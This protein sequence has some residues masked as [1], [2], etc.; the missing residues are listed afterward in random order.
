MNPTI[1]QDEMGVLELA[2]RYG[3]GLDLSGQRIPARVKAAARECARKGFL[4][5]KPKSYSLTDS[6]RS[7]LAHDSEIV[8]PAG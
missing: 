4:A 6:G 5:G 8:H 2:Q 1:T 7:I 3:D